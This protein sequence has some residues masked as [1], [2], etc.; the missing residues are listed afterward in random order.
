MS[1]VQFDIRVITGGSASALD[2]IIGGMD[3]A[4]GRTNTLNTALSKIGA[5]AFHLNN[6]RTAVQGFAQDLANINGP[7]MAFNSQMKDLQAITGV[8]NDQLAIIGKG[9]R[10]NAKD[11]GIDAA[12]GVEAY[13]LI[14]SQLGPQ[15]AKTPEALAAMG[16]SAAVLS[17]QM[18]GDVTAA[19]EVLTTA[20]NQYGVSMDDPIQASKTMA[21]MMDIMSNAAQ[22]GSA[23]L[24]QI[25]SALEASGMMAKTANVSFAELNASIQV[26]DQAGKKGAEGGVA[27][28]NALAEMSQGAMN[29]PKTIA[30][31]QAA[32]ISVAGLADKSRTF[33]ERLALLK[34]IANDT[35]AMTQ[36]FGKENVAAGIALVQ[37]TSRI[38]E[39]TQQTLKAGT[40]QQMADTTMSSWNERLARAN[41]WLKDIGIS[42]TQATGGFIPF[43]QIGMSG[44]Q[45]MANLA[46]ITQVFGKISLMS[47]IRGI[48][49][50]LISMGSWIAVT[51]AATL[52][53]LGLNA[54]MYANPIGLIVLA[55]VA[56]IGA[57]AALIY[58]WDEIWGAIKAFGAW[59]WEHNPFRFLIDVVE[60]IFPGFKKAMGGLWDWIVAKFEA[61]VGWF[62]KAWGWIKSIF[63]GGDATQEVSKAA[64]EEMGKRAKATTIEGI[65]VQGEA[66]NDSPL[67][68]YKPGK[69]NKGGTGTEMA[70]NISSGGSKPTT[71]N[72]TIHK[73]QDQTVINTSDTRLGAKQAS[74]AV[75]EELLI[76]LNS[77]D[78]KLVNN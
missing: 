53:Q 25:K 17:K 7:G 66:K 27:I 38:N 56:A 15:I 57:V 26:L 28:R 55:V 72:L 59:V 69:G 50:M 68:N 20:L 23:E 52:A 2:G 19:T 37:N 61:L 47:A 32:G 35:A 73:L 75:V 6:I 33:A 13:K 9:A 64:V 4:T 77:V 43:L 31:L 39:L 42:I 48:G 16:R 71:I 60:T 45:V 54:A 58:W 44:I 41:A 46:T 36:L 40:A 65:T 18:S 10:Q 34:P 22:Q 49:S 14:L 29:S 21:T 63:G 12:Q 74:D 51:T 1:G 5:A 24:P 76:A 8:T 30:M 11:F 70:S 78:A 3:K 67:K 62:K